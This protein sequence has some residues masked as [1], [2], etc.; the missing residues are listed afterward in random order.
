MQL[1]CNERGDLFVDPKFLSKRF[2]LTPHELQRRM[3]IGLVTSL[4]EA[5]SGQDEGRRRIT[6]RCGRTAWRAIV[7]GGN[8]IT[9]EE[10]LSL[11]QPDKLP[12][13]LR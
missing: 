11:G 4:I 6:V 8:N 9:S 7:D 10:L 3:R 2:C 1:E 13:A 12:C 5:G